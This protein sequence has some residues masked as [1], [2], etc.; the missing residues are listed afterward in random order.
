MKIEYTAKGMEDVPY[1]IE[2]S[3]ADQT[4]AWMEPGIVYEF[5]GASDEYGPTEFTPTQARAKAAALL[6]A[7]DEAEGR[8][9]S[10]V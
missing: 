4:Y 2:T 8:V 3:G 10:E 1:T 9:G 5:D 7:A 6:R